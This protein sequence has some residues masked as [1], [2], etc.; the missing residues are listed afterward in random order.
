MIFINKKEF[1]VYSL[2]KITEFYK[3]SLVTVNKCLQLNGYATSVTSE[4]YQITAELLDILY[5]EYLEYVKDV[6]EGGYVSLKEY[7]EIHKLSEGAVRGAVS[8]GYFEKTIIKFY[9]FQQFI[10]GKEHWVYYIQKDTDFIT[11]RIKEGERYEKAKIA[12]SRY[13]E[14][15]RSH[16]MENQARY[17]NSIIEV[18]LK[19]AKRNGREVDFE[20]KTI[21]GYEI[22]AKG[23]SYQINGVHITQYIYNE[24]LYNE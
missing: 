1:K 24:I 18:Y 10:T 8:W 16:G 20:N 2:K 22:K 15:R 6:K 4:K 12:S 9:N 23:K 21:D 19:T 7:S 17:Q 14:K 11:D 13:C 3:I 5:E